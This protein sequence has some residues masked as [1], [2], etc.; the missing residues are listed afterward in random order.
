[1]DF[2]KEQALA[3][4]LRGEDIMVSAGA[5]AGK[6]RVLVSRIADLISDPALSVDID[7]ILVM[8]F[9]KAAAAEMR[10]RIGLE[11]SRRIQEDPDDR[12]LRRQ[13]RLLQKAS[14]STVHSFCNSIIRSNYQA[15][16]LD[17]AYRLGEKGELE[18]LQMEVIGEVLEESYREGRESFLEFVENQAPGKW[19]TG[20][21]DAVLSLYRF[22]RSF[23][24]VDRW[25][26]RVLERFRVLAD[27]HNE[28]G[29]AILDYFV[30]EGSR[31]V[32]EALT[33]LDQLAGKYEF[34]DAPPVFRNHYHLVRSSLES[35]DRNISYDEYY[36]RL[37]AISWPRFPGG[38]KEEKNWPGKPVLQG[39]CKSVK[40][41]VLDKQKQTLFRCSSQDLIKENQAIYPMIREYIFLT[42]KFEDLY[43]IRKKE[44]NVYDFNDLE[45]M[46]L[47]LLVAG[48]DEKGN[49]VPTE[50]ARQIAG[51]YKAVFVDE[52]QDTSLIQETMINLL[53]IAGEARLFT[54]GDVKQS[55]YRFRQARPDL[56]VSRR[57]SYEPWTDLPFREE[58]PRE[59]HEGVR[60]ELRDNFRSNPRVLWL[61]NQVFGRLMSADFGGVDY[62]EETELRPG[63]NGPM[64]SE[65]APSECIFFVKDDKL[66]EEKDLSNDMNLDAAVIACRVEELLDEGY[67]YRDMVVLLRTKKEIE[68]YAERFESLGI[69]VY[70][71][72]RTGYF[73]SREISLMMDV[74]AI[75]DN[76][77]QDIPMASVLL[78]SIG[79]F[80][81]EDLIRLKL[82]IEKEH[83]NDYLLYDLLLLYQERGEDPALKEKTRHFLSLLHKFRRRKKELPLG[84]L[85][86]EI[87]R[88]TG[89]FDEVQLLPEGGK[90]KQ[91]LLMLLEKAEE[92]EK[93]M[94]KGLFNFKRYMDR[95][96]TYE[97]EPEMTGTDGEGENVVRLMTIHKSKGLEFPIVFVS[98][99]SHN[100]N[101][102]G[103]QSDST[104]FHPELGIGMDWKD[105]EL[106]YQHSSMMKVMIQRQIKKESLEEELRIL[107]V[108]MTRAE[109][110]LIL[111]GT[112]GSEKL[113]AAQS[114]V[115]NQ[116]FKMSASCYMDWLLPVILDTRHEQEEF[117]IRYKNWEDI[118]NQ[119][120]EIDREESDISLK[121]ALETAV[122][123]VDDSP[124]RQAFS[125]EYPHRTSI[126]QK[127]KYSVS[128]LKKLSQTQLPGE[129]GRP[130]E[131]EYGEN[132]AFSRISEPFGTDKEG[133]VQTVADQ[134]RAMPVF[135][136]GE[137]EERLTPSQRG[138]L[139]HKM[140]ELLPFG[141]IENRE[142]LAREIHLLKEACPGL[143]E[144]DS[145]WL[146]RGAASFLFSDLGRELCRMDRDRKLHRE[147][148][149]TIG[150]TGSDLARI[151]RL[152]THQ[153]PDEKETIVVQGVIDL[154]AETEEGLWLIDYKTDYLRPGQEGILLDRY[155]TQMLYYKLA[156]EQL[157]GEKVARIYLYSYSLGTFIA[158]TEESYGN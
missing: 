14:I 28:S 139:V 113:D 146:E 81:E 155:R 96:R 106:R 17:P 78:S 42:K 154:F 156:L 100:F 6:T 151:N 1:M 105:R 115:I 89:Y 157:W 21:E 107:Y 69:P 2:T 36:H 92:Y 131:P 136:R 31:A 93:T 101:K 120:E 49:P 53:L 125:R 47:S 45:H 3:I 55:I 121:E 13:N 29:T 91:N 123:L 23:P 27:D 44:Q 119:F 84:Q 141:E 51:T 33:E 64:A 38:K 82:L 18:L 104:V 148:P 7:E 150:L 59:K 41:K 124:V 40:D 73:A 88:E 77:Y 66:P 99:L 109:K 19:D 79:K 46:A 138:T 11:I 144:I 145:K 74:L 25:Y 117:R 111:T 128:E 116:G 5:G 85:L 50:T 108:A 70:C 103:W 24:N 133:S 37:Y 65:T 83:R 112:V 39:F 95:L 35:L 22:T 48:Y 110:K 158:L 76:V 52:Y 153:P 68:A 63:E 54:V 143:K 90:R 127:R 86:W 137:E 122:E 134:E 152:E 75:V 30:E 80:S 114:T 26:H 87:Y 57:N 61:V 34:E 149:F 140:M 94:Y 126:G 10:E 60:I 58:E 118:K 98:G 102:Q 72:D 129:D 20:L 9:T 97:L 130:S 147:L 142:R 8:T 12:N 67:S 4:S 15:L 43:F 132:L 32:Q 16:G 62:D 135:L 56:F 71:E